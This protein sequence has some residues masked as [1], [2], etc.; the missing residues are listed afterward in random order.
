VDRS[1]SMLGTRIDTAK[2][3]LVYFLKSLPEDS[4]FNVV[5][6]G[7]D[8]SSIFPTP[9]RYEDATLESVL[10][11]IDTF[12]ADMGGT[13]IFEAM[14]KTLSLPLIK[15]EGGYT[16]ERKIF[17]LTDGAVS[18]PNKIVDLVRKNSKDIRVYTVGIGNGCSEYLI[19]QVAKA[20]NGRSEMIKDEEGIVEKVIYLLQHSISD[21]Y[22]DFQVQNLDN[23]NLANVLHRNPET[24][25]V[26][27]DDYLRFYIDLGPNFAKNGP[28]KL[29][30]TCLDPQ[31][32]KME[33]PIIF[34]PK[35]L[36][37]NSAFHR[38]AYHG[39][40]QEKILDS[41]DPWNAKSKSEVSKENLIEMAMK[42]GIM[43]QL[44]SFLVVVK[45][46]KELPPE[47]AKFLQIPN[48]Y[49]SD[50][51]CYLVFVKTL[52]GKK[53]NLLFF[54][55]QKYKNIVFMH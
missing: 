10:K 55:F 44:T 53:N 35:N 33:Y 18:S 43:T 48:L 31:K 3:A 16:Y 23:N 20:G 50:Y 29:L 52:T 21:S 47:R 38:L 7:S 41:S 8:F 2:E 54:Q 12:D 4:Y 32:N 42:Y 34:D 37:I 36:I 9:Q 25:G 49:P 39:L 17:L 19:Q 27:Q 11:I 46:N 30:L 45:E 6:F 40:I 24:G 26:T 22:T 14:N 5:S 15:G 51:G 13:E 28:S 1:G